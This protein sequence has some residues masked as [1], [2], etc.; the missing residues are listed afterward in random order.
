MTNLNHE[1]CSHFFRH[2]HTSLLAVL[3][4]ELIEILDRLGHTQEDTT[5][6]VYLHVKKGRKKETAN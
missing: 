3:H 4:F 6:N 5:K 1:L 2:T